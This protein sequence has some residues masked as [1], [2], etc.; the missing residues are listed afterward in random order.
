MNWA[1]SLRSKPSSSRKVAPIAERRILPHGKPP[2]RTDST[3]FSFEKA[4]ALGE[5]DDA[6]TPYRLQGDAAWDEPDAAARREALR[7]ET[8]P[9]FRRAAKAYFG[10]I[11]LRGDELMSREQYFAIHLKM[12]QALAPELSRWEAYRVAQQDWAEDARRTPEG[13]PAPRGARPR[14]D[15]VSLDQF[16][17]ALWSLADVWTAELSA[18][19]Y[20]AFT[21]KLF[22]CARGGARARG[23]GRREGGRRGRRR[24]GGRRAR[25]ASPHLRT[26]PLARPGAARAPPLAAPRREQPDYAGGRVAARGARGRARRQGRSPSAG[27]HSAERHG[28]GRLASRRRR[29]RCR[30]IGRRAERCRSRRRRGLGADRRGRGQHTG[31]A[32]RVGRCERDRRRLKARRRLRA[33]PNAHRAQPKLD[34]RR[35]RRG[36]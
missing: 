32:I 10:A 4:R 34:G 30:R 29:R 24:A 15:G 22:R 31:R 11:G 14:L 8:F 3:E 25:R 5:L 33:R 16:A 12:A 2:K 20:V 26:R 21:S 19:E 6:L 7:A 9:D 28:E 13:T 36:R 18:H 27:A 17:H 35:R 23:S 1:T